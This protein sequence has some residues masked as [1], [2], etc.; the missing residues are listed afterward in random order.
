MRCLYYYIH[1]IYIYTYIHMLIYS[2]YLFH[3]HQTFKSINCIVFLNK[4]WYLKMLWQQHISKV[5]AGPCFLPS[6]LLLPA[7]HECQGMEETSC[8]SFSRACFFFFLYWWFID[9]IHISS[10]P[11]SYRI[12]CWKGAHVI[13]HV[14]TFLHW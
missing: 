5:S 3:H 14:C 4:I 6:P 12:Y 9:R 2:T 13:K 10:I 7:V 8:W 11:G 1:I